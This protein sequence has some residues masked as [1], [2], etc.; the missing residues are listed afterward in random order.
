MDIALPFA[1]VLVIAGYVKDRK[2][3]KGQCDDRW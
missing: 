3:K 1:M 2:W